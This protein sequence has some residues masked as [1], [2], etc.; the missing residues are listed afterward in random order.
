M[1]YLTVFA[2]IIICAGDE[3]LVPMGKTN[4]RLVFLSECRD[5]RQEATCNYW[6]SKG[7]CKHTYVKFVTG[8]CCQSCR[9]ADKPK[10]PELCKDK[11]SKPNCENYVDQGYCKHSFVAYM[12]SNC[13]QSCKDA[14]KPKSSDT[15]AVDVGCLE[16]TNEYRKRHQ[17]TETLVWDTTAQKAQTF[18]DFLANEN[19][20]V[21]SVVLSHDPDSKVYGNGENLY[22]QDTSKSSTDVEA[23][24]LADKAWYDE[25][26][27]WDFQNSSKKFGTSGKTGHFTQMIWKGTTKVGFGIA[28]VPSNGNNK[29]T[30]VVAKYQEPGNMLGGYKQNVM[31]LK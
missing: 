18:A 20:G 29:M 3:V 6:V 30:F 27:D 16:S 19:R 28:R 15:R 8:E 21:S 14:D 12:T 23:C 22:F 10:K 24:I 7:Y 17:Q 5:K 9:D 2:V 1:K 13:C 11:I 31:P 26:K 25:I 4:D